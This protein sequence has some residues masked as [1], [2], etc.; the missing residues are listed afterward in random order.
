MEIL[1]EPNI[2]Q[3]LEGDL[4]IL[5]ESNLCQLERNDKLSDALVTVFVCFETLRKRER[6]EAVKPLFKEILF[7]LLPDTKAVFKFI[8]ING[9]RGF[10]PDGSNAA[11]VIDES[12]FQDLMR[13]PQD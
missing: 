2:K 9:K 8:L 4:Q 10:F 5:Y 7:E 1:L 11:L 13:H 6:Y 12:R 3:L